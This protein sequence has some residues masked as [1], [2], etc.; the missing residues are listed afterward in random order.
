MILR[1]IVVAIIL[2]S[3]SHL[4]YADSVNIQLGDDSVRL[5]YASEV[6]GGQFGPTDFELGGFFNEDDTVAHA[7][8]VL[9]SDTIDNPFVAAI[10]GRFYYGDVGNA[11]PTSADV[12]AITFGLSVSFRP[13]GLSGLG[14]NAYYFISPSVT[15]YLDADSFREFGLTLDINVTEQV[16]FYVGYRDMTTNLDDGRDLQIDDSFIYG[17]VFRF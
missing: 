8:L 10:G 17:F 6:F 3:V 13:D 12:A 16:G 1:K 15:S 4:V 5:L 9:R 11:T 2:L 14:V 7:S